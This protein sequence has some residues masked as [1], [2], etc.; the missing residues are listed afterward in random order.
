[1]Q[2][3][4]DHGVGSSGSTDVGRSVY[5]CFLYGYSRQE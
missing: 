1:M 5:A 4:K 2:G 3:L